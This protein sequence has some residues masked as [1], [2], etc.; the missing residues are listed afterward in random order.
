MK[1]KKPKEPL[2]VILCLLVVVACSDSEDPQLDPVAGS[3]HF[4]R[5][6]DSENAGNTGNDGRPIGSETS[7]RGRAEAAFAALEKEPARSESRVGP[8]PWPDD[9]PRAWPRPSQATVVADTRRSAGDRLLLVNLPGP[10]DH[11][12]FE[13]RGAL[14]E[15]GYEVES[16]QADSNRPTLRVKKGDDRAVLTF[17]AREKV[18]RIEILFPARAAG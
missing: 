12:L 8:Q 9:L 13:F 5:I 15:N 6:E 2:W 10:L 4:D 7:A 18:T 1:F 17:Y 3:A 11:A 14:V 16:P